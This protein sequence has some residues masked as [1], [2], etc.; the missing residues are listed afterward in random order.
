MLPLYALHVGPQQRVILSDNHEPNG[1]YQHYP[2]HIS[3]VAHDQQ[4]AQHEQYAVQ[5]DQV[6]VQLLVRQLQ[7]R[8]WVRSLG[9]RQEHLAE[10]MQI[11]VVVG[12]ACREY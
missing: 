5:L 10:S 9:V 12:V 6:E 7:Q 1:C 3:L 8:R 4:S 2:A 11:L